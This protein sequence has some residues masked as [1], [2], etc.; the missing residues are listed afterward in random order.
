VLRLS[1]GIIRNA[2]MAV[3]SDTGLIHA[4]EAL[5]T[6]SVMIMGPT[7]RETGGGTYLQ[8]SV[9]LENNNLWCRPCS[10]NGKQTCFRKKQ[11]CMDLITPKLVTE[12]IIGLMEKR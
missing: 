2:R 10:Q 4:A 1:L 9:T 11:Y 7:S 5:G 8:K 3:G 12:K 6:P